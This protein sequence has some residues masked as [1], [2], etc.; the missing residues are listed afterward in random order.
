[1]V[2][3]LAGGFLAT[4]YS[5]KGVLAA[6]VVLWSLFT[7]ATPAAA[8]GGSLP[9]LLLARG[10]MGLGEGVTY[11]AVQTLA[12]RWVPDAKRSRALSFIYSG[13]QLGTV[14]S[15]LLAPLLIAHFGW[16]S[17]FLAFGSLGFVWL[18]GWLPLV[19]DS[20]ADAA[21]AAAEAEPA[22]ASTSGRGS[23]AA[24]SSSSSSSS[25]ALAAAGQPAAAAPPLRVQDVPWG[26]FARSPAFWAIAAAQ[27]S[28]GVGNCLSYSWLPTFYHE[29]YD[30]DITTSSLYTVVPFA[31]T[32]LATNAGGWIADGLVN[33]KVMTK[34]QTRKVMQSV[35]SL[36]PAVCL[37]K[38]AADRNA[39]GESVGDALAM[40]TAWLALSGFSAAGYGSNHQDISRKWSGVL[41]G[42][43]N[44]M[45]SIAGS[46]SIY[47]TGQVLTQ[48]H[49]WGLIFE[50]AAV[51]YTL[52]ALAYLKWA[53]SQEQF[54]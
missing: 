49:D 8:A 26:R 36:G 23:S 16:P 11:P 41:F 53:S 54:D 44:G 27:V 17:V 20:P 50:A 46:V 29:V 21:R 28:V 6:G 33:N 25:M 4:R 45:A 3:N 34:T 1:M 7:V 10:A 42:L 24:L 18:A 32:I 31:V 13:H 35:A 40:V 12:R 5:A 39:G 38:L 22:Q 52:G 47:A 37:L 2:T 43:S 51:V 15:Y 9:T 48:T 19:S 14:S 30:V